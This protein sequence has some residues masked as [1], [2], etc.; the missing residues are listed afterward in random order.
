MRP[1]GWDLLGHPVLQ[2]QTTGSQKNFK[3][4]GLVWY[5]AFCL[6][7][8]TG[9]WSRI[10]VLSLLVWRTLFC[11]FGQIDN[12]FP[13]FHNMLLH[14]LPNKWRLYCTGDSEIQK[15]WIL[16]LPPVSHSCFLYKIKNSEVTY[17]QL[18]QE[19]ITLPLTPSCS[20]EEQKLVKGD[21]T[22]IKAEL[23]AG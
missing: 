15:N 22:I 11:S 4:E 17:N 14:A 23:L 3:P 7:H 18:A 8:T 21:F 12:F 2:W 6:P 1:E 9:N 13:S 5:T 10:R 19:T 20:S 16:M